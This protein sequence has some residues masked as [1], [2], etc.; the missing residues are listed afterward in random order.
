MVL[1][2]MN[3]SCFTIWFTSFFTLPCNQVNEAANTY[4]CTSKDAFYYFSINYFKNNIVIETKDK[5]SISIIKTEYEQ[6]RLTLKHNKQNMSL[7]RSGLSSPFLSSPFLVKLW[8]FLVMA[9]S[10][11]SD[12][13]KFIWEDIDLNQ[14]LSS[15]TNQDLFD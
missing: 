3:Y 11:L 5:T 14:Y 10:D 1:Y 9:E 12:I 4:I 13:L 7:K 15:D 8:D 6:T 2:S